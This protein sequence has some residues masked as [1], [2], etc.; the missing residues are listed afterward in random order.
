VPSGAPSPEPPVDP[1]LIAVKVNDQG[2]ADTT[3][4]TIFPGAIFEF[5]KDDGDGVY[6]PNADDA[7]VLATVPA[8]FGF[9]VFTPSEPG[10]YWVTEASAPP[11]FTLGP[12]VLVSWSVPAT[13]QNC[14]IA[15]GRETCTPDEDNSGGFVVVAIPDS[16]TGAV[17]PI[18]SA[19]P[20]PPTDTIADA[21]V[22]DPRPVLVGL[23]A[24]MGASLL[25]IRLAQRRR[26]G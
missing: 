3:D 15:A 6:E 17:E 23:A 20:L 24:L 2:T 19:K 25:A 12:P 10:S 21:F 5:R 18:A 9:A 11:D 8:T 14:G 4:D 1:P 22:A 26:P 16:P 13:P 7:P